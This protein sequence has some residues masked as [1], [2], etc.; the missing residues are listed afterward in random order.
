[1]KKAKNSTTDRYRLCVRLCCLQTPDLCS[2]TF[3]LFLLLL[4]WDKTVCGIQSTIFYLFTHATLAK[5]PLN[6]FSQ[7]F[8]IPRRSGTNRGF[9]SFNNKQSQSSQ[10]SSG[11]LVRCNNSFIVL[12]FWFLSLAFQTFFQQK[13]IC[14]LF[15]SKFILTFLKGSR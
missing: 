13:S 9:I 2:S 8:L 12:L 3:Y 10:L 4:S 15:L 1:M 11:M 5:T 7:T 6:L 14:F